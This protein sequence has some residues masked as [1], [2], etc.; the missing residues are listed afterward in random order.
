VE[1]RFGRNR[2]TGA[3]R[4]NL[5]RRSKVVIALQ[6]LCNWI[7]R[8]SRETPE[9]ELTELR[10]ELLGRWLSEL[11]SVIAEEHEQGIHVF[12][13][14]VIGSS[15]NLSGYYL[16]VTGT[17]SL[18]FANGVPNNGDN[19]ELYRST[20][21]LEKQNSKQISQIFLGWFCFSRIL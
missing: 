18:A 15:G 8:D 4:I 7:H 21:I 19:R 20:R 16:A 5:T 17:T 10:S 14:P 11:R 3:I 6:Q 13:Q 12:A 9:R 1:G 2:A